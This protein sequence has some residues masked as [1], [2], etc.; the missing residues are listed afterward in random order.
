MPKITITFRQEI[1]QLARREIRSQTQVLRKAS[2]Q[3]RKDIAELK[4]LTS[5]T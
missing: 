4:R 1:T 2:A 5:P 3:L